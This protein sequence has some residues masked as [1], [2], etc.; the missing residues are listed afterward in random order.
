LE[1]ETIWYF[2][3]LVSF[4]LGKLVEVAGVD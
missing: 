3:R 4:T 2:L 1:R